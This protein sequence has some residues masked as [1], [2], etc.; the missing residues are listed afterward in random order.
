MKSDI[1][2]HLVEVSQQ[3]SDTQQKY[4]CDNVTTNVSGN[5]FEVL[6]HH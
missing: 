5:L 6:L 2:V 3:L 4:L 1:D